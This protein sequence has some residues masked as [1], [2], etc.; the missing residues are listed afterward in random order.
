MNMVI[1]PQ[2]TQITYDTNINYFYY[3]F[4]ELAL[5]FFGEKI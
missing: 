5:L 2:N 1:L 3:D 4:L